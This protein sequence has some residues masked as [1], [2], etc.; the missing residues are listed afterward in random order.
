MQQIAKAGE[1]RAAWRERVYDTVEETRQELQDEIARRANLASLVALEV[2]NGAPLLI[3][4]TT[5]DIESVIQEQAPKARHEGSRIIERLN[6][7]KIDDETWAPG[8]YGGPL[9]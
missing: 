8:T 7:G 9:P 1:K 5:E 4:L 2:V 3:E 6:G